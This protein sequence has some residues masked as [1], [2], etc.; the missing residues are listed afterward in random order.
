[1]AVG[2]LVVG[3]ERKPAACVD[4]SHGLCAVHL[5]LRGGAVGDGRTHLHLRGGVVGDGRTAGV[6]CA[7]ARVQRRHLH[8]RTARWEMDGRRS[9]VCVRACPASSPSPAGGAV[10]GGRKAGVARV[11]VSSVVTFTCGAAGGRWTDGRS[12]AR[13]CMSSVVTFICGRRVSSRQL[14]RRRSTAYDDG[15][16]HAARAS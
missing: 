8:L 15:A 9:V 7:C 10:G 6:W 1:M 5:H 2:W 12:V 3:A 11:C 14:T 4:G 13:V 16:Q